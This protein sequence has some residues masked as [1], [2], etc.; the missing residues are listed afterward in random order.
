VRDAHTLG[1]EFISPAVERVYGISQAEL[2]DRKGLDTWLALIEPE[3]RADVSSNIQCVGKGEPVMQEFRIRRPADG[4]MRWIRDT[5]FA[6]VDES[7]AINRIGGIS[8]DIT[9]TREWA[10]RNQIMVAEL[11]HRT[12]NL[13]AVVRSIADQTVRSAVS[14]D[15]FR[16]DFSERL[17]ALS[18]V[19]GLLSRAEFEPI[20]LGALV[21]LELQAM[22][23]A[24]GADRIVTGGPDVVIRNSVVQTLSLALHELATNARKYGALSNS[25]G[26][27]S[28]LWHWS[29]A[30]ERTLVLEWLE[31]GIRHDPAQP[32]RSSG[33]FGRKLIEKALPYTVGA[34]TSFELEPTQLRCTVAL[35][36]DRL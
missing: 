14:L 17:A 18:R 25:E 33:G 19:Q 21:E 12:R 28:V 35:P 20:T 13:I 29:Q 5:Q 10:E 36:L 24:H 6:L 16:Q 1:L 26:H 8:E 2:E 32:V 30:T 23:T 4:A 11:Q 9:Q 31:T 15:A 3:H 22:G 7:G 34:K 27:L